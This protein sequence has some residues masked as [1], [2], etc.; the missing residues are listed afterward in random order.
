MASRDLA[1]HEQRS[2]RIAARCQQFQHPGR[3]R[4]RLGQPDGQPRPVALDLPDGRPGLRQEH[5]SLQYRRS[6][7]VVHRAR[8]H[9]GLHGPEEGGRLPGRHERRN[10]AG[11]RAV[12]GAGQGG[13]VRRAPEAERGPLG[14]DLLPGP[15]RQDRRHRLYRR[16]APAPR[17]E[18]DLRRGPLAAPRHRDGGD[19]AGAAEAVRQEGQ[20]RR[21][22]HGRAAR[23]FRVR[24]RAS[25]QAGSLSDRADRQDAPEDSDRGQRRRRARGDAGRR[26][27][28]GVV[29]DH[30][31]VIAARDADRVSPKSTAWTRRRGKPLSR[32]CRRKTRSPRLAWSWARAG[33]ALVP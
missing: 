32:S 1:I 17:Q 19:G 27:G 30:T 13:V 18:H 25:Q 8:Q 12:P 4:Q 11:G 22:Q 15:V 23:R 33:P 2:A 9:G 7:D 29:S 16:Q 21:A 10:R 28:G 14:P 31:L 20:G 3:D 24:R 26:H 6:A 5:V